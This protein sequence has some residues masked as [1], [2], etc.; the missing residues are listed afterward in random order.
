MWQLRLLLT[1]SKGLNFLEL[2]F[3]GLIDGQDDLRSVVNGA[4]KQSLLQQRN[5]EREGEAQ[6]PR[7]SIFK[8]Y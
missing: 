1:K 6:I 3:T 7:L 4:I 8:T 5:F 2:G